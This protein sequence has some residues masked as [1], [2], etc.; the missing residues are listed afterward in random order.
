MGIGE[1]GCR[2]QS[3][4]PASSTGSYYC[5]DVQRHR[6]R[7]CAT[8]DGSPVNELDII[9]LPDS[10]RGTTGYVSSDYAMIIVEGGSELIDYEIGE[11]GLKEI[12]RMTVV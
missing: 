3:Y 12:G 10:R 6:I 5:L 9:D 7:D 2:L 1:G 11:N 4:E 8:L